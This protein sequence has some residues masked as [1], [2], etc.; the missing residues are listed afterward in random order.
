ML[1]HM[2]MAFYAREHCIGQVL[3]QRFSMNLQADRDVLGAMK[4]FDG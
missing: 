3:E 1:D 2:A 4:D